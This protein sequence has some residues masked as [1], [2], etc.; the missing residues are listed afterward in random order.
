MRSHSEPLELGVEHERKS[1]FQI[2]SRV[3]KIGRYMD[4]DIWE[5]V[6]LEDG[7]LFVF[8]S[9]AVERYPGIYSTKDP[10]MTYIIVYP[11]LLYR[12]VKKS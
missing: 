7:R 6:E 8:E 12:E 11:Q 1:T 9:L 5:Y 2:L 10:D 3:K 4:E